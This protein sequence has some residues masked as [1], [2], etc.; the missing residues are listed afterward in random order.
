MSDIKIVGTNTAYDII[1]FRRLVLEHGLYVP[2]GLFASWCSERSGGIVAMAMAWDRDD[3][4]GVSILKDKLYGE[5]TCNVGVYVKQTYRRSGVG[6]RLLRCV[7]RREPRV[8][9][10]PWTKIPSA[11]G[12][13]RS[14]A[15]GSSLGKRLSFWG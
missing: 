8:P 7:M 12:F 3:P 11:Q 1:K 14:F 6:R 5:A 13:Y 9:V 4:I 2:S 10:I 15:D